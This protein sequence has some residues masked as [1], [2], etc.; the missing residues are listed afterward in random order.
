[1][2]GALN[3]PADESENQITILIYI[4]NYQYFFPLHRAGLDDIIN[5]T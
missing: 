4:K 5:I 2:L 1:M 3:N